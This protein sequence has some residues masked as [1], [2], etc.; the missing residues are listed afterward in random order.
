[1]GDATGSVKFISWPLSEDFDQQIKKLLAPKQIPTVDLRLSSGFAEPLSYLRVFE[2]VLLAVCSRSGSISAFSIVE[3]Q[4]IWS[5]AAASTA[6]RG[7]VVGFQHWKDRSFL[8]AYS[9]DCTIDV[10]EVDLEL[11]QG[12]WISSFDLPHS[13]AFIRRIGESCIASAPNGPGE[14]EVSTLTLD[15]TLASVFK[16]KGEKTKLGNLLPL[17]YRDCADGSSSGNSIWTCGSRSLVKEFDLGKSKAISTLVIPHGASLKRIW[18]I[19]NEGEILVADSTGSLFLV[20]S[21]PLKVKQRVPLQVNGAILDCEA[22]LGIAG[23]KAELLVVLS[24]DGFLCLV[25]RNEAG[26]KFEF[27]GKMAVPRAS[28]LAVLSCE[29]NDSLWAGLDQQE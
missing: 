20:S 14:V 24:L 11:K 4:L 5:V 2:G 25:G 29:I 3:N 7:S 21:R 22:V 15:L 10:L 1:M 9:E 12:K 18:P 6:R 8:V 27:L 16:S 26:G 17:E 13:P 23:G 28:S 19:G